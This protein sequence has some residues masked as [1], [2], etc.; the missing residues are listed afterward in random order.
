MFKYY[1][2]LARLTLFITGTASFSR[3]TLAL[4]HV[5]IGRRLKITAK[6]CF[7]PKQF[8]ICVP[9]PHL[10]TQNVT[11]ITT[12]EVSAIQTRTPTYI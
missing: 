3:D 2:L 6:P 9:E 1:Q 4:D 10:Y 7:K 8:H 11:C 12:C 5:E